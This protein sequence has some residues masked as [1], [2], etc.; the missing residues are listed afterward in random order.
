[1]RK[2]FVKTTTAI[3]GCAAL[4]SAA[5]GF[6]ALQTTAPA[7]A[8][9]VSGDT[10]VAPKTYE[11]YLP[12]T[13]PTDVAVSENYTAIADGNVL[14]IYDREEGV[15]REYTH[16]NGATESH[17]KKV[18]FDEYETLYFLDG[19][20][21]TNFYRFNVETGEERRLDLA[22]GTF[23][24]AGSDLYFTNAQEE[25]YAASLHASDLSSTPLHWSDGGI[26]KDVSSLAFWNEELYFIQSDYN[27]MKIDPKATEAPKY[28]TARIRSFLSNITS[29]AIAEG[30]LACTKASGDLEAYPLPCRDET[31]A[32]FTASG[33]FTALSPF[34]AHIYAVQTDGGV[35]KQYSTAQAAFTDFEI[36]SASNAPN[37]FSGA[38][39]LFLSDDRL[40][41]ADNANGRV[42][43]YD[44]Q[45]ERFENAFVSTL[46][47]SF[48]SADGENLIAANGEQAAIYALSGESLGA[49]LARFDGFTGEIKGVASVYGKHYLVTDA[50]YFYA[51][52]KAAS[53]EWTKREIK[54]DSTRYPSTLVADAYG[55]LYIRSGRSVYAFTEA[56]F[57]DGEQSG[58]EV[59]DSLPEATQRIA[60]DYEQNIY[61]L[62]DNQI[63]VN[64]DTAVDFSTPL[65]YGT[66]VSVSAF[67][68]G[69]EEN[70]GYLLCD[71]S[72]VIKTKR[73]NLPT[74]KSI[75]VNGA[76]EE[77]FSER[78]AN[79]S[80]V[81]TKE[82]ALF[83]AFELS[84][85]KEQTVFPYLSYERKESAQTALKMG[86]AGKYTLLALFDEGK[87]EYA[88]YLVLTA[89]CT[90]LAQNEY[91]AVYEGET[92]T[93]YI[94]SEVTLYKFPYLNELLAVDTLPRN[95]EIKLLGEVNKLD[96]EY[97]HVS[98]TDENGVEKTGYVPKSYASTIDAAPPESETVVYG[99]TESDTDSVWRLAY[100][101]LGFALVCIL[102]DY[103]ILRK[104]KQ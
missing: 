46:S 42:S 72:Y 104:K 54:K 75:P 99:D 4:L 91:A 60:V 70:A 29:I 85:L 5:A 79:V 24:V 94:T 65:V 82:N 48:L 18:Q 58:R 49:E 43:V 96:H 44:T 21:S 19:S 93:G 103:L 39:A 69:I 98:Y 52:E 73:L 66:G 76:D 63:T 16:G 40:F 10:L 47:P 55:N 33:E 71:G 27:L 78:S 101:V 25:L 50:N 14:Y 11:E 64:G 41:I 34:G 67:A 102:A 28:G 35:I 92:Q 62:A 90:P 1:M 95:A 7:N 51:F 84:A 80:V 13:Q 74:V 77:I 57:T 17:I 45:A 22:C 86:E 100:L 15:Y 37:R 26:C 38:T 6:F 3:F 2:F 89:A 53:G 81:E 20:T 87:N 12:L 56:E 97:Y 32:V 30:V 61:A 23:L 31:E 8:D 88:T 36:C 68:F 9:G 83:I 59:F